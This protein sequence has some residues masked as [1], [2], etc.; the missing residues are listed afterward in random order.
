MSFI[1]S[2][3]L[4][5]SFNKNLPA[6]RP[7]IRGMSKFITNWIIDP[8][9]AVSNM[10][11]RS[12]YPLTNAFNTLIK[13]LGTGGGGELESLMTTKSVTPSGIHLIPASAMRMRALTSASTLG[14][15]DFLPHRIQRTGLPSLVNP[16]QYK[17]ALLRDTA[18]NL[19]LTSFS[20]FSLASSEYSEPLTRWMSVSISGAPTSSLHSMTWVSFS[21][22]YS[23]GRRMDGS[24]E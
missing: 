14:Y 3:A 19:A 10:F 8:T 1:I 4:S 12:G 9:G 11:N 6:S 2:V 7:G 15:H 13:K 18:N 20:G 22:V 21:M 24:L 5:I 23:I 16:C 17:L